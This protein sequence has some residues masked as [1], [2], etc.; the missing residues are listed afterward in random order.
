MVE[1]DEVEMVAIVEL[2][3]RTVVQTYDDEVEE[4]MRLEIDEMVEVE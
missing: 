4:V 1:Y 2:V 3:Q